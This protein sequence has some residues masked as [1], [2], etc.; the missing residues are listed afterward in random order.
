M[1]WTGCPTGDPRPQGTTSNQQ[2]QALQLPLAQAGHDRQPGGVQLA[3]RG[4]RASTCDPVRL[5]YQPDGY[6]LGQRDLSHRHQVGCVHPSP[7]A[8]TEQQSGP[9]PI[10][11]IEMNP[12][13]SRRRL[14]LNH[15]HAGMLTAPTRASAHRRDAAS[16]KSP[17]QGG[18]RRFKCVRG[19]CKAPQVRPGLTE[20]RAGIAI[21]RECGG[22]RALD[23]RPARGWARGV[24]AR[25]FECATARCEDAERW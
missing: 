12:C 20:L 13:R 11:G 15:S 2:R 5:L 8:M 21:R 24:S 25:P 16:P 19:L 14:D 10:G 7:G 9:R 4:G 18:G 1:R 3:R 22:C 23:G 17:W 6:A